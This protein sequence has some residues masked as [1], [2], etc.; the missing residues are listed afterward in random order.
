MSTTVAILST[1]VHHQR[2]NENSES[3]CRG[4]S[5]GNSDINFF[6]LF[7]FFFFQYLIARLSVIHFK[8]DPIRETVC[9][10]PQPESI[11]RTNISLDSWARDEYYRSDSGHRARVGWLGE[12]KCFE[13]FAGLLATAN[14][15]DGSIRLPPSSRESLAPNKR[16]LGDEEFTVQRSIVIE[17]SL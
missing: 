12:K 14:R 3:A 13:R 17:L 10:G 9:S 4:D 5:D 6:L 7:S 1:Q 15:I 11:A 16:H 2:R 8:L